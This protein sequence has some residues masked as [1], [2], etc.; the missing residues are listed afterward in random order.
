MGFRVPSALAGEDN[1][2]EM[3]GDG[4]RRVAELVAG[5]ALGAGIL[6]VGAFLYRKAASSVGGE[7]NLG[8][9]Y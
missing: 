3:S 6:A 4:L 2:V 5:T 8:D 1:E 7:Q 9:L